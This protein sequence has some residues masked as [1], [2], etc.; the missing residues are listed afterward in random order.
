MT[1]NS[2]QLQVRS[3]AEELDA[4]EASLVYRNLEDGFGVP[5]PPFA[6]KNKN[7]N[8]FLTEIKREICPLQEYN[9]SASNNNIAIRYHGETLRIHVRGS[10]S[11]THVS[12]Y[13]T[14]EVIA[15]KVWGIYVKNSPKKTAIDIFMTSYSMDNNRLDESTQ[16]I[17]GTDLDCI[18]KLYYPYI[19]ID[20]MFEQ[21]FTSQE[22]ILV[23]VGNPGRGKSKLGTMC[24]KQAY[25]HPGNIPY[26]KT[27]DNPMLDTQFINVGYIK[28]I[29]V[30]T[31]DRFW[32]Q[33]EEQH[34]DFVIIDDLDYMLTKRDSEVSSHED[35]QKNQFLNQFLSF[36]DGVQKNNTKFII[37][38]N[39]NYKD[40]D[41]AV[42]RKGRLF[43]IIE[44]R[45]L[46]LSEA[47]V[48]WKDNE[49]SEDDFNVLFT[50]HEVLAA[51][52]GSEISKRKNK[53]IKTACDSYLK[54]DGISKIHSVKKSRRISM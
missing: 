7:F 49:L 53:R 50:E 21:F 1:Q 11:E 17:K 28:S 29:D 48:I 42:L 10:S 45:P 33:L 46:S 12:V 54:E 30:L 34:M 47:L 9:Y 43:D 31:C 32:R 26:D 23:L 40:I 25:E 22:N 15:S 36:T 6:L 16:N 51:D 13:A 27:K 35:A 5:V 14:S 44:L 4:D 20:V 24:I 2:I 18:S 19:D 39:Q 41:A 3:I 8:T 52:L 37:T 38:T